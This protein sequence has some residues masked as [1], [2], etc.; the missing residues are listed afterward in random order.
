MKEI[1]KEE[2]KKEVEDYVKVLFRKKVKEADEQQLFQAVSYAVKDYIVDQWMATH[3]TYEEKDVKTVYYLS[4]E[5]LTGRALGN[6]IINLKGN[7][8]IKEAIEELG[9]NLDVIEDQE[10]DAAL[11]NGGLGRLAACF[12]D[13]LYPQAR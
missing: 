3:R 1:N 4:M 7:K 11:G 6:I 13:S 12:L 2:F 5:F 9:M 10:P 8:A